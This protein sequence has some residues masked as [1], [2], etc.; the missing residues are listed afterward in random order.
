MRPIDEKIVKMKMDNSDFAQKAQQTVS[1]FSKLTGSFK[2]INGVS[3]GKS[4]NE[5]GKIQDS[6]NKT[7]FQKMVEGVAGVTS[8]FSALGVMATTTLVNITNRAVNAG[9][10]MAK[11]F[12]MDPITEGFG[13]YELKM[14]SIQTI[15]SNTQGKSNLEDVTKTLGELNEYADKTIYSFADMTHNIGQFTTAG[16]SL[17]DSATAIQG[18]SN[19]AAVS[20]SNTQ[21]ASTAM[22]QLSQALS[23]GKVSLMDWNSV[24]NAGMGGKVFQNALEETAKKLGKGR[25]MSVSF[26]DSLEQGWLTTEVLLKTLQD[27]AAD[28][29][30]L[31]AATKVR[32]FTQLLDT[33]K[34]AIGS[35]WAT[36]WEII[37]GNFE[38]AGDMW[39]KA[40]DALSGIIGGS[41]EARNKLLGDFVELGGRAKLID[42]VVNSF[43]ALT[44]VITVAGEGFKKVFPPVTAE[45]LMKLVTGV[46][47]FTKNL[48]MNEATANKV[49]TIFEGLF[50]IFDIGVNVVKI[51]GRAIL[52]LIPD[53]AGTAILDFLTYVAGLIIEFNKAIESSDKLNGKF[54]NIHEV[55]NE[56]AQ[57]IGKFGKFMGDVLSGTYDIISEIARA[58]TPVA[59][60]IGD[61]ISELVGSFSINDLISAGFIGSIILAAKKFGSIS[62]SIKEVFEKITDVIGGFGSSFD[63]FTDLGDAL[64]A[65][66]GSIKADALLKIAGAVGILAVSLKLLATID[67]V[68]ISKSL[69]AITVVMGLLNHSLTVIGNSGLGITNAI[70]ASLVL[71]ALAVAVLALAGGLKIIAGMNTKELIKGMSG[72]VGIVVVLVA[73]VKSLSKVSRGMGTSA[74]GLVGLSVAVVILAN[75][76]KKMSQIKSTS[77]LKA[78]GA[79]GIMLAEL[80]IFLKVVDKTKFRPSSA[81]GILIISGAIKVM[82][83]AIDDISKINAKQLVKGLGVIAIILAEIAIFVKVT[84]GSKVMSASVGM[85]LV[86]AA[87]RMLVGPIKELGSTDIGTLATGLTSMAV[88]LGLVVAAMKLARGGLGGATSIIIVAGAINMLVPPIKTLGSMS[89]AELGKGLG[90]LAVG[91]T[92]IAVAAKLIG[93]TGSLGLIALAAALTGLGIAALGISAALSAFAAALSIV[94]SVVLG[95]VG[96]IMAGLG[97]FLEG[98]I[99]LVPQAVR[100]IF[101]LVIEMARGFGAAVPEL[102]N[103]AGLAILGVL[104]A[105][106]V[107]AP[108]F[109][110]AGIDFLIAMSEVFIN[111]SGPLIDAGVGMVIALIFAMA[112]AIRDNHEQLVSAVLSA[113]EAIMEVIVEAFVTLIEVFFGWIP[114]VSD[115]AGEMGDE[116]KKALRDHFNVYDDAS[117]RAGEFVK[118]IQDT[119]GKS[120]AAGAELGKE[121]KNGTNLTELRTTGDKRGEEFSRGIGGRKNDAKTN[122]R[123][124]TQQAKQ[125]AGSISLSETAKKIGEGYNKGIASKQPGA[126]TYGRG[127]TNSAKEGANG[128]SMESAGRNAGEGFAIGISSK[129]SRVSRAAGALASLAKG[130]LETVLR[131][132]SPSKEMRKD[133]NFFGE[134]F[135]LGIEDQFTT[136]KSKASRMAEGAVIAVKSY[137]STFSDEMT[138][139]LDMQPTI[140]PVMDLSNIKRT[141]FDTGIDVNFNSIQARNTNDLFRSKLEYDSSPIVVQNDNTETMSYMRTLVNK[142]EQIA[143]RP[144]TVEIDVDGTKITRVLANPMRK[145][146]EDMDVN[147]AIIAKGRV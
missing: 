42:I 93:V 63:I 111:E 84:S 115:A 14:K 60:A 20:G 43:S 74:V 53:G 99:M 88:A 145:A 6:V 101:T 97:E 5:L 65:M 3:L 7:N 80:A 118:G 46:E 16:V 129:Q 105:I 94:V 64:N 77:L 141:G 11:S 76:V 112:N 139:S 21:Q 109:A 135:G 123:G 4:V 104:T 44:K 127:L 59:K 114:G 18:I 61:V 131:I 40:N 143:T 12:T 90:A 132:A 66:T 45:T 134:G 57:G 81:A 27:F 100:L 23:T 142:V 19:L 28:E 1:I 47:K 62:D 48:M 146:F 8:K 58:L 91:L 32:T 67:G 49:R 79:L 82:V 106:A 78:V 86:A 110:L 9:I 35:G 120:R 130:A 144:I 71:P 41:A 117:D 85:T 70:S 147:K 113:I 25:D 124:L 26:R 92:V 39:T 10:A 38:E 68:D 69:M 107:Y 50:S 33:A 108:Q 22:Y 24:V 119:K 128:V 75:A 83:S 13:E 15:L 89:L 103:A 72:L 95:S 54:E 37:F 17:N 87:I 31:E 116:A 96:D 136:V 55:V 125:G 34:E 73:A 126:K 98:L 51:L 52:A 102:A 137:A 140:T 121:A 29:S 56:V 122:G 30:M 138:K 2:K 36:T 133:G